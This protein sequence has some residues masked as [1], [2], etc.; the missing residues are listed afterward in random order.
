MVNAFEVVARLAHKQ[1]AM[2]AEVGAV[3]HFLGGDVR[4]VA[5]TAY[6]HD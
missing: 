1:D 5:F 6:V 4:D 3:L 2:A